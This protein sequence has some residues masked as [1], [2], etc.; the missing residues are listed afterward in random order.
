MDN[1]WIILALVSFI[2]TVSLLFQGNGRYATHWLGDNYSSW[3]D[4]RHSIVG[5]LQFNTFGIPF[6]GPDICGHG[7]D[8]E[9]EMC[10][11]EDAMCPTRLSQKLQKFGLAESDF[12]LT[13]KIHEN[14]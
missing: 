11:R 1:H 10:L 4:L 12:F 8:A 3:D 6:V 14:L 13:Q 5:L 7:G 2:P 9:E